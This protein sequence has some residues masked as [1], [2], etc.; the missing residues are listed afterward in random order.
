MLK[1]KKLNDT[2]ECY[3]AEEIARIV[4]VS[5]AT[6]YRWLEE[7]LIPNIKFTGGTVRS[8]KEEFD[9]FWKKKIIIPQGI[10]LDD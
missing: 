6:A 2:P 3:T 5:K 4:K 1:K 8:P 10:N 9:K 7:N